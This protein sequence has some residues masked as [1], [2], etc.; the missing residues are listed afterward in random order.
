MPKLVS[1]KRD[2]Y[3][4]DAYCMTSY[5]GGLCLWLSEDDCEKLGIAKALK[6]GTEVTISGKAIAVSSGENLAREPG[7]ANDVTVS[8]QITDLGVTVNGMRKDAAK[9]LYGS[10]D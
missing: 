10:N 6:P 2:T 4:E 7:E 8:L 1:V 5:P 9:V 3:P